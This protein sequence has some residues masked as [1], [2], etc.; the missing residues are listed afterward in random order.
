M[1][2]FH[3]IRTALLA[4]IKSARDGVMF[5]TNRITEL[6]KIVRNLDGLSSETDEGAR[7]T[8]RSKGAK[9]QSALA[10]EPAKKRG[11]PAV[12][13]PDVG[14]E[15]SDDV[16]PAAKAGKKL[17]ATNAAFWKGLM[18]ATPMSNQEIAGAAVAALKVRLSAEDKKKLK[19]R[20][21]N[22]IAVASKDGSIVAEGTGRARR[23]S[24]RRAG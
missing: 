11:R 1:A 13:T 20:L 23:F 6:E 12:P 17:P 7:T 15:Q 4:E 14:S 9:A 8:G 5:Y 21:A 2:E 22:F 24:V 16:K 10:A 19:Q 18:S 3:E